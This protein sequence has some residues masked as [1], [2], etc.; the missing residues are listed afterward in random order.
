MLHPSFFSSYPHK[1]T[2]ILEKVEENTSK[3]SYIMYSI[4]TTIPFLYEINT[5]L[6]WTTTRTVLEMKKWFT[7]EEMHRLLYQALYDVLLES[8]SDV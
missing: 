4:Y 3:W 8:Q 6:E 5:L 1:T 2:R 7:V